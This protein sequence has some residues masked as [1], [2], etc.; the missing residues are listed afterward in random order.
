M[1]ARRSRKSFNDDPHTS[2]TCGRPWCR[3]VVFSG[4]TLHERL[5]FDE[6]AYRSH[7]SWRSESDVPG[8]FAAGGSGEFFSLALPEVDRVVRAAADE[9]KGRVP[10]LAPAG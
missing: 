2:R 1:A 9:V 3:F 6:R 5:E 7:L 8:L 4:D 10:L